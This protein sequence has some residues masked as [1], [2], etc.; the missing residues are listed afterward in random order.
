MKVVDATTHACMA[1]GFVDEENERCDYGVALLMY[2]TN[3]RIHVFRFE[4][5][6]NLLAEP[7]DF[8]EFQSVQQDL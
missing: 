7:S 8:P 4:P 1:A 6:S 2:A 5:H 3:D